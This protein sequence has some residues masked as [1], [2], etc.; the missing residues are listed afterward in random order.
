MS[1]RGHKEEQINI[2]RSQARV[3]VQDVYR[4]V[5]RNTMAN[6]G[7]F[8]LLFFF[9]PQAVH[10]S[11]FF[12]LQTAFVSSPSGLREGDPVFLSVFVQ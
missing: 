12:S 6:F 3:R 10:D 5:K 8:T 1:K 2:R 11:V 7:A 9:Y 4:K